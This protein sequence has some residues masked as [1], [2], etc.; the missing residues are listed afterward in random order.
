MI[1]ARLDYLP[2]C[3][4]QGL[5]TQ[6][7]WQRWHILLR[8][9]CALFLVSAQRPVDAMP[10]IENCSINHRLGGVPPVVLRTEES[11][12]YVYSL[13][14]LAKE[15]AGGWLAGLSP[16]RRTSQLQTRTSVPCVGSDRLRSDGSSVALSK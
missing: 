14:L 9:E 4:Y 3:R 12:H 2:R 6:S 11:F 16:R 7:D 8:F 1:T 10:V 5:K 13:P 15:G